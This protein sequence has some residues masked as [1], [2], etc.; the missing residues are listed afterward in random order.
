MACSC[1]KR[2][3]R[4]REIETGGRESERE[5]DTHRGGQTQMAR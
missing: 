2:G 3:G 4:K 5:R 1:R